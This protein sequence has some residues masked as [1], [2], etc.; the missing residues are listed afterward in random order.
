MILRRN[1]R[2]SS[3][4]YGCTQWRNH[5]CGIIYDYNDWKA[6]HRNEMDMERFPQ[7]T[8]QPGQPAQGMMDHDDM[9][10]IESLSEAH[11]DAW[12]NMSVGTA[13]TRQSQRRGE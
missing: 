5:G 3:L 2:D 8:F 7:W 1:R 12:D 13:S 6:M 4:F 10:T 11:L 9:E